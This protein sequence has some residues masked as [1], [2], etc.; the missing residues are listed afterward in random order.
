MTVLLLHVTNV[1]GFSLL[2][3]YANYVQLMT[4]A[5]LI[6]FALSIIVYLRGLRPNAMLAAGG[7]SG[8]IVLTL[9]PPPFTG[10]RYRHL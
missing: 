4:A 3:V 9:Y 1:F 8:M 7:N 5:I 6:S 10:D 2:W